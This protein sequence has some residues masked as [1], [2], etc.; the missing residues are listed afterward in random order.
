MAQITRCDRC[1]TDDDVTRG[2]VIADSVSLDLCT[3]CFDKVFDGPWFEDARAR[4]NTAPTVPTRGRAP[5]RGPK[6]PQHGFTAAA[7]EAAQDP[8]LLASRVEVPSPSD[9]IHP[10]A[11]PA[12]RPKNDQ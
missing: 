9:D 8:S 2:K 11:P 1:G 4:I 7:I 5:G 3:P 6:P 10:G 12:G